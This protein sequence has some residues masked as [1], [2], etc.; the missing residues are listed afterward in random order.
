MIELGDLREGIM[1]RDLEG[2][3][4]RCYALPNVTLKAPAPI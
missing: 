3:V 2:L 1:P 4:A